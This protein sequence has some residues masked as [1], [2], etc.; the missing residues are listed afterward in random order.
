MVWD[1]LGWVSSSGFWAEDLREP[2]CTSPLLDLKIGCGKH[3][4]AAPFRVRNHAQ[5]KACDYSMVLAQLGVTYHRRV[6]LASESAR[7][8]AYKRPV[9]VARFIKSRAVKASAFVMVIE[10]AQMTSPSTRQIFSRSV[11]YLETPHR[12]LPRVRCVRMGG[13]ERENQPQR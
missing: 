2:S 5:A 12:I 11:L 3:Y 6:R 4:V 1:Y 13:R 7:I 9:S 10:C 8:A